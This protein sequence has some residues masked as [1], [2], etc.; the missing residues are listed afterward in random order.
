[1]ID[2]KLLSR[3]VKI[4]KAAFSE[5]SIFFLLSKTYTKNNQYKR[6]WNAIINIHDKY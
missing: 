1:M 2:W 5:F 3:H 4:I 6:V